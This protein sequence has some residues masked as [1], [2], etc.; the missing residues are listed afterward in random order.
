[1]KTP[2]TYNEAASLLGVD[3]HRIRS[4]VSRNVLTQVPNMRSNKSVYKEQV[5]L[6]IGKPELS[7]RLLSSEDRKQWQE[8]HDASLATGKEVPQGSPF[9]VAIFL[10][11]KLRNTVQHNTHAPTAYS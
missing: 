2:I 3:N 5:E 6:F 7:K 1:M 10:T 8:I 11:E 4:A 9:S